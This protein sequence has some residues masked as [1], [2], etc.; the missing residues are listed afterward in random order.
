MA[1]LDARIH[2]ASQS[3]RRRELLTQIGVR[4]DLLPF[5]GGPRSDP[6]ISEEALPG[7]APEAYALRVALAK[8]RFGQ[9]LQAL[10][11]LPQRIVLA[12]DTTL[13]LDGEIIGKPRDAADALAILSR[14]S[15]RAHRVLTAVAVAYQARIE[16]RLSISEVRFRELT[17]AEMRRYVATGEPHDKAGAYGI[18]GRAAIFVAEIR[19]SFSGIAGLPLCETA[20]LLRD[21]GYPI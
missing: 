13:D 3:P 19:G 15:G 2:L 11:H 16:S 7:E 10:R 1:T 12:A 8:A 9:R 20:L 14:L 6:E 21:L 18:Q 17:D 4:F 5:R